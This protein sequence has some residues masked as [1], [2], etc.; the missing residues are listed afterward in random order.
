MIPAQP[1]FRVCTMPR[2]DLL[3][4][5]WD[6]I[7]SALVDKTSPE[8]VKVRVCMISETA[9][10]RKEDGSLFCLFFA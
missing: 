7:E 4:S 5:T 8:S 10:G 6:L 1:P 3:L 2:M 9:G